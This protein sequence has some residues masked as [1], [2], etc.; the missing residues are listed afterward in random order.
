VGRLGGPQIVSLQPPDF[1]SPQCFSGIGRP[2]HEIMHALGVFHEQSR[3]DRSLFFLKL[4]TRSLNHP[5]SNRILIL[6]DKY[7]SIV[8]GNVLKGDNKIG[9]PCLWNMELLHQNLSL[10]SGFFNN[11]D[12]LHPTNVSTAYEYDFNSIMHYGINF[13]SKNRRNATV[14]PKL[15]VRGRPV[16]IGQRINLSRLDCMKLNALYGCYDISPFHKRQYTTFCN[17]LGL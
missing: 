12:K 15:K 4:G 11:F 6:R 3:P 7:V 2:L 17:F 13:F 1:R 9:V 16:P 5:F 14:V 10:F 8:K